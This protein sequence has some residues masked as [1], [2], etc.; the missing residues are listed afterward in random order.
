MYYFLEN[1]TPIGAYCRN[2]DLW[3]SLIEKAALKVRGGFEH[4]GSQ[5]HLDI[6]MLT[7]WLPE[8]NK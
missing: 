6:L 3:V 4:P 2:G 5:A 7:G 8:H 1:G